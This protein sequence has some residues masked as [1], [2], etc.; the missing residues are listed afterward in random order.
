ML[1]AVLYFPQ[2]IVINRY[3][4]WLEQLKEA[5][6]VLVDREKKVQEVYLAMET[7][8]KLQVCISPC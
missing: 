4:R 5:Q 2:N 3:Y 1:D 8:L 6:S 7:G